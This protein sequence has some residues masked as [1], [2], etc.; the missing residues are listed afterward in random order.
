[1]NTNKGKIT[2]LIALIAVIAL[3]LIA[4]QPQVVTQTVIETVVVTQVVEREGEQ[5]VVTEIVE[6]ERVVTPAPEVVTHE[7][8]DKDT[9]VYTSFG[10]PDTLDPALN[11]E[12]SG[13]EVIFNVYETL[14]FY[15]RQSAS[16]VVP[17]L[18]TDWTISDDGLVY[19]FNIRPG[20]QFHL[21]GEMTP[22]DVAYSFQRAVLQGGYA[23]PMWLLTEPYFGIGVTDVGE[24]VNPDVADD[25]AGMQAEDP[26]RLAE[27]CE[28]VKSAIVADNAAGT[29]TITLAQP[30]GPFLVTIAQGW[31]SVI[32]MEWAIEQG[33]WDGD[34]ATWQDY[35]APT[36]ETTPLGKVMNGTGP[37]MFENWTPGEGWS[38]VR[39]EN[40]WR[41]EPAWEGGPTGP[42]AIGRIVYQL[43]D[44]WGTRFAMAQ[45]G[46]T[47]FVTVNRENVSQMDPLVGER[48]DYDAATADFTCA[49]TDNPNGPLSLFYGAPGVS[50]TD[51]FFTFNINADGG[52]PY[53]GSGELDGN[54]IPADFFTD[55]NV[56]KAFNYCFDHEAFIADVLVGEG[57]QNVGVLIPGMPGYNPDGSKYD[58]DLDQ[59]QAEIEA[60][61]GGAVAENGFR[62]QVGFN[63]GN[64][65]RQAVAQILQASFQQLDAKYQIEVVGL[66][67]PTFLS[68]LGESRL[69]IF[70]SGWLEDIH[71]PHNWA[72]PFTV[73]T[74]GRRQ[75][76][77]DDVIAQYSEFVNAGVAATDPAERAAIYEEM[78]EFDYETAPAIRLAVAT[79]RH[80]EQRWVQ[81]YYSNPI[82]PGFYYYS[83]SIE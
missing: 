33:A 49:P 82:Y 13:N 10:E 76:L 12:T 74:Y 68:S 72:Q 52:N 59:C 35:Y 53:I 36:S 37:Y 23:S 43:V 61:W 3:L 25:R 77:P 31:A 73:G 71:D 57:V 81:G 48:C 78:Q 26:A 16:E 65:T 66:P 4:C 32:P 79:G 83:F 29:V 27:V 14:V 18:A 39:N 80:Y 54:G 50:R 75:A 42:A 1:M 11:Y 40:Y 8:E 56:R 21:G 64:T 69:P 55:L 60:A 67:W 46:D 17:Q 34:C 5:V 47:D 7:K 70:I 51:A 58:F 38:L 63:T 20:V 41:T 24:L 44:E 19:T 45:V 9:L 6:V 62:F 30:W 28:Q 22:E 15:N 2:M